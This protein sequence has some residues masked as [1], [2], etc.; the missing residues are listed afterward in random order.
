MELREGDGNDGDRGKEGDKVNV[1]WIVDSTKLAFHRAEDYHQC[2]PH[3]ATKSLVKDPLHLVFYGSMPG[4]CRQ[5][6]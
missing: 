3:Y 5:E 2:A 1:V 4:I 6:S